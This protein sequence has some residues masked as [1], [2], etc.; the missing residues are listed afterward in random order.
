MSDRVLRIVEPGLLTTVQD[1]GRRG[2]QRY[3]IPVCGALD[4]VSLRIANILVG[5]RESH[6][7]LELTGI[8]PTIRFEAESAIAVAGAEFW[9]TIDGDPVPEWESVHVPAGSELRFRG[10]ADGL[11]AYLAVAGGIDVPLV[12]N[13][14]SVL[15]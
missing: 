15:E 6:A 13:S 7:G 11:R 10:T 3:G 4:P 1:L 12:M 8:G 14:R 5:N 9:P 2:F